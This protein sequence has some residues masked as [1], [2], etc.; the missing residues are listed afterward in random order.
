[1]CIRVSRDDRGTLCRKP[2]FKIRS[3]LERSSSQELIECHHSL[4]QVRGVVA[5]C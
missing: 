1:M 3:L 4:A 2:H 5:H